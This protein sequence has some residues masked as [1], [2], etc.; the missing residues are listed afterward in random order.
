MD[1]SSKEKVIYK[2]ITE[3]V[4]HGRGIGKHVGT[5]TANLRVEKQI[6]LPETG[7]YFSKITLCDQFFYGVTHI[8]TR[9]TL[10][11][12]KEISIETHIFNFDKDIYGCAIT[13][14]LYKKVR[15]IKKFNNLSLL[16]KQIRKDCAAAQKYWGVIKQPVL[17][18]MDKETHRVMINSQDIYLSVKEFEVLYILYANPMASFTKEQIYSAVWNEPPI[19]GCHA[20]ENTIF[21][22]RKNIG[23]VIQNQDCIKT[24]VGYGY[25][26]NLC[27]H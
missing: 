10:D 1:R 9:P 5:P 15:E 12:D 23:C 27:K 19:G 20:V 22:I 3:T 14:N 17:L 11:N 6:D 18:E 13:I 24:I 2:T 16:L 8:G 26:F 25:K 4:I 21:Q 7:V